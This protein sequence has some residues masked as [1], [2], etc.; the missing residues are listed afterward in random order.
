MLPLF[1]FFLFEAAAFPLSDDAVSL[2]EGYTINELDVTTQ[3]NRLGPIGSII[4]AETMLAGVSKC[5]LNIYQPWN[6][7]KPSLGALADIYLSLRLDDGPVS[8]VKIINL[9]VQQEKKCL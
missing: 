5:E 4:F 7:L 9:L 3:S 6:E 1:L 2:S 8:M